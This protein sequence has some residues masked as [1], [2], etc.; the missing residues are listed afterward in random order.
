MIYYNSKNIVHR[1]LKPDNIL[2]EKDDIRSNIK[3]IDFG[4]AKMFRKTNKCF[5][6]LVGTPYYIAPEVLQKQ[7]NEK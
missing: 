2:L 7:Y 6:E 3:I 1:D 5:N 4:S